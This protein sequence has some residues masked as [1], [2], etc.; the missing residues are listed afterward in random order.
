METEGHKLL[1]NARMFA[2]SH[3]VAAPDTQYAAGDP[4]A[5]ILA[6]AED[7]KANYIVV[8]KRGRGKLAGLL[9]GSVSQKL[10]SLAPTAVIVVP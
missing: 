9:L 6:A 8:G 1:E 2:V 7:L 4:A 3:G 10:V 5:V